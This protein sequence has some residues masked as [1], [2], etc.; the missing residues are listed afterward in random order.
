MMRFFAVRSAR[1]LG[2][3]FIQT[4][5]P[6]ALAPFAATELAKATSLTFVESATIV[7]T[8]F[9]ASLLISGFRD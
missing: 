4:V 2:E 3:V 1:F 9:V 6:A 5:P 7:A 8:C